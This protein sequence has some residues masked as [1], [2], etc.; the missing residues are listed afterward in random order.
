[1]GN[2]AFPSWLSNRFD[3]WRFCLLAFAVAYGC[4]LVINLSY[5]SMWWD[6]VTHFTGGLLLSR[7]QLWQWMSNNSFYPPAFDV[8]TAMYYLI[9][10]GASVFAGRLV[11]VTFSVLSLFVVYEIARRMYN[12]KTALFS[13]IFLGV[14]PGIVG[15]SRMAMIETMLLFIF[16]VSMLNFF[17]WLRSNTERDLIIAVAAVVVG[18]A[19]KYQMLVVVPIIMMLSI[20]F[21][22]RDYLNNKAKRYLGLPSLVVVVAAIAVVAF[23]AYELVAS[24]LMSTWVYA[25]QVGGANK[26][27]YSV[28]YPMPIFYFI[29]MAWLN[30]TM[31]PVSLLLYIAGLVGLGLLV[32]RRG[33]EDRYLL[34]W[35]AVVYLVFTLIP[36]R[37]WR[38]VSLVFPVLAIAASNL[39]MQT[40]EKIRKVGQT[41]KSRFIRTWVTKLAVVLLA[42]FV[43]AG[44]A[45]SCFEAYRWVAEDQLQLPIEQATDFA[46]QTLSQNQTLMVAC[47]L[48]RFN[49]FM[50]WFYLNDKTLDLN[51]NQTLQ[52]PQQAVDAFKPDFNTTKFIG[53]CQ[54]YNVKYVLLFEYGGATPYFNSTLTEQEIYLMLNETNRFTLKTS[55]GTNP[56]RIFILSFA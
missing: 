39:F 40:Y 35:F 18:V 6:E 53:L 3:R 44:V 14:M 43:L 45:Y 33:L 50:V 8:V 2:D 31:H 34:L 19:V 42:A 41:A 51:Q 46:A 29:E 5:G 38:Y 54:Q 17:S 4:M 23:G 1:M 47:P 22:K 36:N 15:V 30:N 20:Y 55:F 25:L 27:V 24:G 28:R 37:E 11:A 10:G 26:A 56:N 9:C 48:N 13:A 7:G 32:Y 16:S 12:A 52:Y 21:W 49:E